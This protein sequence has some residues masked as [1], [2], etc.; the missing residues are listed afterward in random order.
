MYKTT[1]CVSEVEKIWA[2]VDNV[3]GEMAT[4]SEPQPTAKGSLCYYQ[5]KEGEDKW[6][7]SNTFRYRKLCREPSR[8]RER[9]KPS[10]EVE[11][12]LRYDLVNI[13]SWI[14]TE[15]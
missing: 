6:R 7:E 2:G 13:K 1:I 14:V 5:S 11:T 4:M 15:C 9:L 3:Y 10:V 12:L 8:Q